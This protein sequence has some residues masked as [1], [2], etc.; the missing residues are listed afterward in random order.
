[1]T[2]ALLALLLLTAHACCPLSL[3][4]LPPVQLVKS[5]AAA[6]APLD[7]CLALAERTALWSE[8]PARPRVKVYGSRG[9]EYMLADDVYGPETLQQLLDRLGDSFCSGDGCKD[10]SELCRV[11]GCGT[12]FVGWV[13][14]GESRKFWLRSCRLGVMARREEGMGRA[15]QISAEVRCWAPNT[16]RVCSS[17]AVSLVW[18]ERRGGKS[19]AWSA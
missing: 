18:K 2:L 13:N 5:V 11:S 19:M 16:G 6:G 8:V 15:V 17:E 1:L 9:R 4:C 14:E 12:S 7:A 3:S 10:S